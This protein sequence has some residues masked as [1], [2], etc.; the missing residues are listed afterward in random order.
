[1]HILMI[2]ARALA[3]AL[4]SAAKTLG[5]MSGAHT[6]DLESQRALYVQRDEYRP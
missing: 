1:M 6:H 3:A 5:G 4:V 2:I